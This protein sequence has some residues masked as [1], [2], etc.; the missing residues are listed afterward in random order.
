MMQTYL[1]EEDGHIFGVSQC[2]LSPGEQSSGNL[3]VLD[4]VLRGG[5]LRTE[6]QTVRV[7]V[8]KLVSGWT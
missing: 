6:R 8:A 4:V 1:S 2:I 7:S 3:H 5:G